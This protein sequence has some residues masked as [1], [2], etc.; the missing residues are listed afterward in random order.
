MLECREGNGQTLKSLHPQ[1]RALVSLFRSAV[2]RFLCPGEPFKK[3]ASFEG[4]GLRLGREVTCSLLATKLCGAGHISG[5]DAAN[6]DYGLCVCPRV[7]PK[8]VPG[9]EMG[10]LTP[11]V[12][13][14]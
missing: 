5:P 3:G 9:V 12:S 6:L 1:L 10:C 14:G 7:T 8:Q 13:H 11:L 4:W 2:H